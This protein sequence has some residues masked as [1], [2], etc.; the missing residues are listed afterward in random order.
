MTFTQSGQPEPSSTEPTAGT[1]ATSA[2][3][4]ASINTG[5]M[6][7]LDVYEPV[8]ARSLTTAQRKDALRALSLIKEKR[9]GTLKGR[10]VADGRP[11]RALY[12]KSETASPTV[13]TDGIMLTVVADAHEGRDVG[14]PDIAGAYLKAYM[15]DFVVM[16]V[17]GQMVNIL[18][19]MNPKY[20]E[21]VILE[22][23]VRTLYVRLVK[24]IYGC[25][26][27]A[28]LWYKLFSGTLQKMGFVLNSYDRCVANCDINGK[29]CT[30]AWYVNDT[31]I[32]HVDP[33]IVTMIIN[34]LEKA[35]GKMTVTRGLSHVFLGVHINYNKT[36]RTAKITMKDYLKEAIVESGLDIKKA[37]STLPYARSNSMLFA[38]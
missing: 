13:S 27:S 32:S 26:K 18:C 12:D 20:E 5:T 16:K 14:T 33:E 17:T 8:H 4:A 9:C 22:G 38:C 37:A 2:S 21:Y 31:K 36:E 19:K 15:K 34:K 11:Q 28:L 24:A 3:S 35:F 29:Q 25:V 7:E 23:G 30:I 1:A 10:T 6:E